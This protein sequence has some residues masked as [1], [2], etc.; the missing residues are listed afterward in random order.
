M[1]THSSR[2]LPHCVSAATDASLLTHRNL[3]RCLAACVRA[4]PRARPLS[5][6]AADQLSAEQS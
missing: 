1:W 2:A 3:I 4:R 5:S 6:E